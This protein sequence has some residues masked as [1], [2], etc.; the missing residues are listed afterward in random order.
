[1]FGAPAFH[2]NGGYVIVDDVKAAAEWYTR[3]FGCRAESMNDPETGP[4]LVLKFD[5]EDPGIALLGPPKPDGSEPPPIVNATKIGK[6]YELLRNRG[7]SVGPLQKD[8]QGTQY[9][10]LRDCCGNVLEVAEEP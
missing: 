1:M 2:F 6:A 8:A 10:E 4:M 5:D 9:F 7:A 3:I